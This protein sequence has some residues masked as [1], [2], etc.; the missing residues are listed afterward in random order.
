MQAALFLA[1]IFVSWALQQNCSIATTQM[2]VVPNLPLCG[3]NSIV[4]GFKTLF[5]NKI[6]EFGICVCSDEK[7]FVGVKPQVYFEFGASDLAEFILS[8]ACTASYKVNYVLV[9]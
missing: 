5:E 3:Q 8:N 6:S 2:I 7:I 1:P 4:M 9:N